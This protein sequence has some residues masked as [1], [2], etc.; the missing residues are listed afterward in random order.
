[1]ESSS[2][3]ADP[4]SKSLIDLL[5]EHYNNTE[6]AVQVLGDESI[7]YSF[8]K[9]SSP[10]ARGREIGLEGL[11]E[12]AE[13]KWAAE[14]TE[15]IIKGEYEVLDLSGEAVKSKKGKKGS[16]SPKNRATK[17]ETMATP[18]EEVDG[19]ELV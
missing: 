10:N 14:Q 4:L 19:F 6:S 9:G 8:A 17:N 11:V 3:K 2:Q 5:P 15:R 12:K 7:L 16:R 13:R 18:I 1:M